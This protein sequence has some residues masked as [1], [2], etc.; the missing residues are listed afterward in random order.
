MGYT[1]SEEKQEQNATID[2]EPDVHSIWIVRLEGTVTL[3]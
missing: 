2:D 3:D 1:R